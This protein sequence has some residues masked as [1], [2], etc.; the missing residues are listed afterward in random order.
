MD[1]VDGWEQRLDRYLDALVKA[2]RSSGWCGTMETFCSYCLGLLIPGERKSMEPVAARVD[3]EHVEARYASIQRLITDSK[4]DYQALLAAVRDY[5]LPLIIDKPKLEAWVVDDTT[6]PKKGTHSVGVAHQYCGNLGKQ[7][8]C[9]TAVS[10]SLVNH[11]AGLPVA[12]RLYLPKEWTDD[13]VR[14]RAVGVPEDVVFQKKWE[15]ALALVDQQLQAGMPQAPFLGDAG[16]GHVLA[17]RQG[18]TER[19]FRYVLG[20]QG[21]ELIWPPGWAPLSK[22]AQPSASER[23]TTE[24]Y[25]RENPDQP[26]LTVKAFAMAL[27]QDSWQEQSWRQGTK[28]LLCSRFAWCRVRPTARCLDRKTG[29][30]DRIPEEEW[31]LVEWPEGEQEPTKYWV[32]T[33]PEG[34]PMAEL[35]DL[36]KLRWRIE[37]D[38][39]DLKQEV[40]LG[41][42]EGR[43]WRGFHHN[44]SI[45]I[46][47]YAFLIAERARL[48]PPTLRSAHGLPRSAV[49]ESR[50]WRRPTTK[51][52]AS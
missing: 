46:A 10:I 35:I 18:L 17:F 47:S 20:T 1:L 2:L 30:I 44:A 6:F 3:P 50:P 12:Y 27:P 48:F 29:I 37:E 15:I 51:S 13:P 21:S 40:G 34:I 28:E 49:P 9:Q 11:H 4:W 36:A 25:L 33:M 14:C 22:E 19:G 38:Y 23:L 26:A 5:C 45:C 43:T 32:S 7:A 24:G 8:N 16:Y 42:F 31:L 41:D 39:E 52:S